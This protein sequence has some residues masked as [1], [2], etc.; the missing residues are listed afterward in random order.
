MLQSTWPPPKVQRK[1]RPRPPA[2]DVLNDHMRYQVDVLPRQTD[3]LPRPAHRSGWFKRHSVQIGAGM[4]LML[5]LSIFGVTTVVPFVTDKIDHWNCGA[6][7]GICQYD[8]D[9]GHGGTS[10]FLTQYWH[11]DVL[12]IEL[13]V[14]KENKT[15]VY[16]VPLLIAGDS[17]N[18]LVTLKTAFVS[19]H[20]QPDKPDLFAWV[21]G[22][23]IPVV[24]YNIGDA[25]STQEPQEQPQ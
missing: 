15:T 21:E 12:V 13:R 2:P 8:L 14:G 10:H 18:R 5:A 19:H 20:S 17:A 1:S 11:G 25:F 3:D 22:V 16:A 7:P 9:V 4:L 24:L 23:S 6:P